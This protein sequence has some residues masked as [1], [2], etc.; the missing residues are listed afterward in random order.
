MN[1]GTVS[2]SFHQRAH[3]APDP[4]ARPFELRCRW[5]A[6]GSSLWG[7]KAVGYIPFE[8]TELRRAASGEARGVA[9]RFGLIT[10]RDLA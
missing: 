10:Q 9:L 5:P 6:L 7:V 4:H 8:L 1:S 3:I 2:L